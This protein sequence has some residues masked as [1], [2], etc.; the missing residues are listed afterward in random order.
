MRHILLKS[1]ILFFLSLPGI[2]TLQA[3]E[4]YSEGGTGQCLSCH[5]F[6]KD[7]PVHPMMEGA[8]GNKDNPDT[9]M[10]Q[11]GCEHCHG[12][13]AAH[14]EAPTKTK[15]GTS[16]GPRWSDTAQQQSNA[17]LQCHQQDKVND[18]PN[19]LHQRNGLTCADCHDSHKVD[20]AVLN[21]A[22]Q[23][24]VCTVCH[25]V[26]KLGVHHLSEKK[27]EN[28]PC[29]T[30]HDPHADPSPVV[31]L[32]QNRSEGCRTCHDFRAMQKSPQ[33]SD[34]AKQYHKAMARK[35]K[36]C[37]DCHRGVSHSPPNSFPPPVLGG[38]S[39]A[40]VTL[41]FPGQSD[42]DWILSEHAGA[43][44]FRQGRNCLQCHSG[45]QADMGKQLATAGQQAAIDTR[46]AFAL[47]ADA[48]TV[49]I[50]WQGSIDDSSISLMLDDGSDANF[51][52]AGCWASCHSDMPGMTRDRGQKLTKYLESSRQ[53]QRSIGRA[54]AS[55]DAATLEQ[56]MNDS[57]YIEMWRAKLS[58]G[59]LKSAV[60]YSILDKRSKDAEALVNAS[61]Q[62][63]NGS[64]KVM[65]SKPLNGSGKAISKGKV[66][67]F[68]V[69]IHGKG[70][71]EAKHWVSLPMTF[72]LDNFD[73]DFIVK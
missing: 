6:S 3:A 38:L 69:A 55:K 67:T 11:K 63:S 26:Q 50:S 58:R 73:T 33:V 64:W 43:Q 18:W 51:D 42:V 40:A 29:A 31:K 37:I 25:K 32:L 44:S 9:P 68:G 13:S 59:A 27:A 66:Y 15:P 35:D 30:C 5:D 57:H 46:I 4:N 54:P 70:Q 47:Q 36:T 14:T 52:R 7:S 23:G 16:F 22:T 10:A 34:Q 12:P 41:F 72:S 60:S 20:Q 24:E 1:L 8:H 48:M 17:C 53:Q 21:P 45:D 19:A 56:M 65:F 49:T 71:T 2:A 61:A 39:A 62:F 28:P